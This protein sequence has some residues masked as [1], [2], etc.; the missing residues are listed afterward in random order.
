MN[1]EF[2]I[3]QLNIRVEPEKYYA[4]DFYMS[5]K[6]DIKCV[7]SINGGECELNTG[8]NQR[9]YDFAHKKP[10]GL[11]HDLSFCEEKC[12][13]REKSRTNHAV[14]AVV[15][16]GTISDIRKEML[17]CVVLCG[18]CHDRFDFG[19]IN[20]T[21][22]TQKSR[23]RQSHMNASYESYYEAMG[24]DHDLNRN[25][26]TN[27]IHQMNLEII[28]YHYNYWNNQPLNPNFSLVGYSTTRGKDGKFNGG[29]TKITEKMFDELQSLSWKGWDWEDGCPYS[30]CDKTFNSKRGMLNHGQVEHGM[31]S[32]YEM[33]DMFGL[34][35]NTIAKYVLLD[36]LPDN[37]N[38]KL[39]LT[40]GS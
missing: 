5:V 21:G 3:E 1:Y 38:R 9:L 8:S 40:G 7:A 15:D 30:D 14:S 37:G 36:Q 6:M 11:I 28:E 23:I 12:T 35:R 20:E 4:K 33:S 26:K 25:W 17:R 31:A 27:E 16:L 34:S 13:T 18:K 29:L 2:V 32:Q 22:K 10:K 24:F 39:V 19:K